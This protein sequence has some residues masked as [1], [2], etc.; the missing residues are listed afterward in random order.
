MAM[1]LT[2]REALALGAG[3]VAA[4]PGKTDA[5]PRSLGD[6]VA[7]HDSALKG[8]LA[9]QVTDSKSPW[10][11]GI[12]DQWDLY[13]RR[14]AA[15]LIRDMAAA[16]YHPES[17]FHASEDLRAR[18]RLAAEF[19]ERGQDEDGFIDLLDTNFGSPPD[20]AF[21]VHDVASAAAIAFAAHNEEGVSILQP[22]L[23]RAGK[24]LTHGGIHTPNHRWVVC[25]ALAQVHALF[26]DKKLLARIEQ[27]LAEGI[28][29]DDEGQYTERST[30][31][32]NTVVDTALVVMSHYLNRPEL[33]DPVR[34]NLDAMAYLLHPDGEVVTEISRRQDLN[35]RGTMRGYWFA[36]R[37]LALRD[38][39]GLYASMLKPLEP[40]H[41][42][43]ARMMEYPELQRDLPAET[44]IP[45]DYE[46]TLPLS[47]VTRIRRKRF[48]VTIIHKG[49]SRW[50][51]LRNGEAAVHAVRFASAF[52][53]KGQWTP[54]EFERRADGTFHFRQELMGRYLQPLSDPSLLPVTPETW[55]QVAARRKT[56]EIRR[57]V[58]EATIR[59]IENGLELHIEARGTDHVPLAIEINLRDGGRLDNV[60]AAP[61]TSE[62]FLLKEG[63]A[64]YHL[65]QDA[66]R[67]GPGCYEH[68]Y[69]QVR[70]GEGKLPGPSVFLTG[71][72]PFAHTVRFEIAG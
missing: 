39:N 58:Y 23:K 5:A 40:G 59:E 44:S 51:S 48:S 61:H 24:G 72:T 71:F 49:N 67:F 64:E 19:L 21:V 12:P 36:L 15:G 33:L 7:K 54:A 17:A 69:V 68:G 30:A 50:V 26:P 29:I 32:Y 31:G 4:A 52:F 38:A 28:D 70:G 18:M 9:A 13:H 42:E 47:G 2:R 34:K 56:T 11:G 10:R 63:M 35:T 45:D 22:F 3:A 16:Y 46:K 60:T 1:E 14:A 57:M 66:I 8:R 6:L 65:G 20:T 25:A 41:I 55:P 43:L 27:W 62:G 53:G 37:Y